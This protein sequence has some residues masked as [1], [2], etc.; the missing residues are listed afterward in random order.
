M[1]FN[2]DCARKSLRLE[3]SQPHQQVYSILENIR[4]LQYRRDRT[5]SASVLARTTP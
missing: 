1:K 5:T 4:E 3:T 2:L